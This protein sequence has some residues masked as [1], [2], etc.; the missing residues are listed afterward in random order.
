[1]TG[2]AIRGSDQDEYRGL[3]GTFPPRPIRTKA[4]LAATEA[5]I[6][7]L[8][9]LPAR[10]RAQEDYLDLLSDLVRIWED[11]HVA[12]PRLSG[13]EL[14]KVLCEERGLRQRDLVAFFGTP[15][16][17]SEVLSGKRALQGKHIEALSA[18]FHV[19]PAVFFPVSQTARLAGAR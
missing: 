18:F 13:V 5:C 19:S 15:S 14:L 12:I 2:S 16:I 6:E 17:V 1:M 3:V 7:Q 11:K 10:S 9:A 8:L 4:Q